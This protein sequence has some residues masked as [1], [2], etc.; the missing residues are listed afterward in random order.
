M[1][2]VMKDERFKHIAKDPRFKRIPQS[3]RKV[4]IDKR[5]QSMFEDKRFKVKY[6]VDKRGRPINKTSS[7]DLQKFYQLTSSS[8]EEE[9]D[10]DEETDSKALKKVTPKQGKLKK[11]KQR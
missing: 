2:E 4:K 8:D 7:E 10:T 9:S 6:T 3:Q 5:F 1:D 11:E